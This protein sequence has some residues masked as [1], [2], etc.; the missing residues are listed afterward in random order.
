LIGAVVVTAG[1]FVT[2]ADAM[3][4][5]RWRK[6]PLVVFAPS[7]QH[8]GLTQQ[9]N[10]INGNRTQFVERDV[11]I[12]YVTGNSVSHD[13][14]GPQTLNASALRQRY[15]VSEGQFR[16]MLIGKDGGIKIDQ[17][18]PL[19]SV[20]LNAEI[21]RMPMRRDEARRRDKG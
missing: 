1:G 16:V 7:D 14:G 3:E 12:V 9:R 20:D 4:N 2:G 15:K 17:S 11:V 18:T 8:P 19:A 13:L 10:I 5:Y 6:R 21:D